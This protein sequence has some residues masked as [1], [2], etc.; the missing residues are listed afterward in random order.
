MR[1]LPRRMVQRGDAVAGS[2]VRAGTGVEQQRRRCAGILPRGVVQGPG[3]P[4]ACRLYVGAVREQLGHRLLGVRCGRDHQRGLT[5]RVPVFKCVAEFELEALAEREGAGLQPEVWI[6]PVRDQGHDR[7]GQVECRRVMEIRPIHRGPGA[8]RKA[9]VEP[10][11]ER[12]ASGKHGTNAFLLVQDV[13]PLRMI[14]RRVFEPFAVR[15]LLHLVLSQQSV[16]ARLQ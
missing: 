2:G 13:K 7:A 5:V 14:Q 6:H 1:I 10:F 15:R 16:R 3:S 8:R 4:V 11:L 12:G 9:T